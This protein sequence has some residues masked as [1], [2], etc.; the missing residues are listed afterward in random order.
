MKMTIDWLSQTIY[1]Y[2]VNTDTDNSLKP[3]PLSHSKC[4]SPLT[5]TVPSSRGDD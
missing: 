3:I 4:R 1:F 2:N 5:C